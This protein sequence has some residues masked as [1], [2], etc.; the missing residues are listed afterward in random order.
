MSEQVTQVETQEREPVRLSRRSLIRTGTLLA[1]SVGL[2]SLL[3]ACG[4]SSDTPSGGDATAEP[5]GTSAADSTPTGD[6]PSDTPTEEPSAG[7]PKR[8]G[9]LKAAFEA[10]PDDLNPFTMTSLVS[11]LVVEKVYD[12]LF[13]FNQELESTPN[14]CEKFEAPD[15]TTYIFHLVEGVKFSNGDPLT[16]EDVKFSLECYKDPEIGGAAWAQTIESVEVIDETTVQVNLSKP[17]APLISYLSWMYY[18]IVSKK[19][20]EEND[21]DLKMKTMGSG[22]FVLEEFVPDQVIKLSRNPH[23]WKDDLPYLDGIEWVIMPDDQARVAALRGNQVMGAS[24]IDYQAAMP[25]ENDEQRRIYPYSALTHATTYINCSSGPLADARVRQALS[26]AIDREEILQSAALGH[27]RVT[28][29]IPVPQAFW[30][31]P[32]EE[33]PTYSHNI[34]K[35]KELL[36][37]AGYPDG[38]DVTLRVSPQYILDTATAQVL[39]QQLKAIGVNVQIEQLEWANLLEAWTNSDFEMLQILLLGLPD[40]DGYAWGRYHSE[41]PSNYNKLSDPELDELMDTARSEVDVDKR[42][43]LY[44]DIQLKLDELVPNLF[45]FVY[46]VWLIYDKKVQGVTPHPDA[47]QPWVK[48]VWIAD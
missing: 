27:G 25:F 37:E 2:T 33:L 28:G 30:A 6:A 13:V 42:Q 19:F 43:A 38:F 34:E 41:S 48:S 32:P 4:G 15:E 10:N 24:F 8:G 18:P 29:Y 39:Q 11:A 9:I 44:R 20:Y 22:P 17:Y 16:A 46:D 26:Y 35:A 31:V 12:T 3:A 40:P 14:L 45:H 23:Y 47:S 5:G 7:E 36:A 21:G 1:G